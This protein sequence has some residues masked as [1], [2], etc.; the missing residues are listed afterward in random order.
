[1]TTSELTNSDVDSSDL[2]EWKNY[3]PQKKFYYPSQ[4]TPANITGTLSG[5]IFSWP[6]KDNSTTN[7]TTQSFAS[8]LNVPDEINEKKLGE[9]EEKSAEVLS[10]DGSIEKF[11]EEIAILDE[12]A[13]PVMNTSSVSQ[14]TIPGVT[15]SSQY[16]IKPAFTSQ[17]AYPSS[18]TYLKKPE[19]F[20]WNNLR[21]S[22]YTLKI[23]ITLNN[24]FG[25]GGNFISATNSYSFNPVFLC[26]RW[27]LP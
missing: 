4:V 14:T 10:D 18:S 22:M 15:F 16:S 11:E 26:G 8:E 5:T 12:S 24:S 2:A 13:F 20:E 27:R 21:S 25:Y 23:P 1:M 9:S 6:L 7:K 19:D 17:L 3:T